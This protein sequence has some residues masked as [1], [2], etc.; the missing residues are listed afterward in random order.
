MAEPIKQ[1]GDKWRFIANC[2]A[3]AWF[4][5]V[6]TCICEIVSDWLQN[7]DKVAAQGT[8]KTNSRPDMAQVLKGLTSVKLRSVA[9]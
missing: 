2:E 6:Y 5:C 3:N 8:T 4:E 1:K 9:R 7:K